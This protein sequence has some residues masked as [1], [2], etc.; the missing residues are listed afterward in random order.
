M[1]SRSMDFYEIRGDFKSL[2]VAISDIPISSDFNNLKVDLIWRVVQ[3]I[4]LSKLQKV[5]KSF[6]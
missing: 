2:R 1:F 6:C 5:I 3:I 4:R